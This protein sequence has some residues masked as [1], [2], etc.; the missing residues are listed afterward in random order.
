MVAVK[1]LH[2]VGD[3]LRPRYPLLVIDLLLVLV[4]VVIESTVLDQLCHDEGCVFRRGCRVEENH[5]RVA[6]Q[7]AQ[8]L[9]IERL[10]EALLDCNLGIF[11]RPFKDCA[12]RSLSQLLAEGELCQTDDVAALGTSTQVSQAALE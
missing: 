10:V 12:V 2:T 11:P 9:G 8:Y 3:L 1:M 4:D 5:I 6:W 7:D